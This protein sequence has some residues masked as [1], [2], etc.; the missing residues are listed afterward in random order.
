M[1]APSTRTTPVQLHSWART[2][3]RPLLKV[4]FRRDARCA[5]RP[6]PSR[7]TNCS[8]T[9]SSCPTD[10]TSSVPRA[11]EGILSVASTRDQRRHS[12]ARDG[13]LSLFR[14]RQTRR[15]AFNWPLHEPFHLGTLS[16]ETRRLT[17]LRKRPIENCNTPA[18]DQATRRATT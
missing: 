1:R 16:S 5:P 9:R 12:P 13:G 4:S 15:R 14:I 3:C 18:G 10:G 6:P 11:R 7:C 8:Y 17:T 2:L